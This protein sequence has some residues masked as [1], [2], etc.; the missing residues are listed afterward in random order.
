M[1]SA[2]YQPLLFGL[3]L[4]AK[5]LKLSSSAIKG[6]LEHR[7]VPIWCFCFNYMLNFVTLSFTGHLGALE[8]AG[9]SIACVGIQGLAYRIIL[10]MASAFQTVCGQ[11]YGAKRY[12]AMGMICQRAIVL[13]LAAAVV[14]TFLHWHSALD[15]WYSQGLVRISG[16]LSNPTIALDS[17]SICM[18]YRN[19]DM[20]F[21]LG[22]SAAA[23][24]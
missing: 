13:H 10:G 19:W 22:I 14:L 11:A 23:S 15:I 1:G 16:L 24:V 17:I 3:D 21:M 9:A 5:I 12:S 2:E 6:F 20:M 4:D 7:P 8:L 18:N